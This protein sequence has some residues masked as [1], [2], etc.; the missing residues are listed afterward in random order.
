MS[1]CIFTFIMFLCA[2]RVNVA[3]ATILLFL[4]IAYG[5][6]CGAFFANASGHAAYAATLQL[7]G[8]SCLFV[9]AMAAWWLFFSLMME[10]I[11]FPIQI[12]TF[13]LSTVIKGHS[14]LKMAKGG[15]SEA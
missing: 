15:N 2:L 9:T 1:M 11:D 5:V 6:L 14:E 7:T 12:P 13:D 4:F 10:A 8:G 3:L